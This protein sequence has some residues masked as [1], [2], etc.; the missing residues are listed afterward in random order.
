MTELEFKK[1][2]TDI[3]SKMLDNPYE[4]GIYPTTRCF[5]ELDMVVFPLISEI[6]RLKKHNEKMKKALEF[7]QLTFNENGNNVIECCYS[8]SDRHFK[9]FN[10]LMRTKEALEFVLPNEQNTEI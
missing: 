5:E 3:I 7:W 9:P 6:E 2:R 10:Q 8:D 4:L 1:Q